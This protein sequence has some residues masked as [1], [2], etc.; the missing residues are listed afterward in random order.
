MSEKR[1]GEKPY[2]YVTLKTSATQDKLFRKL[3]GL[4]QVSTQNPKIKELLKK[5]GRYAVLFALYSELEVWVLLVT[6]AYEEGQNLI[7]PPVSGKIHIVGNRLLFPK[8]FYGAEKSI[9]EQQGLSTAIDTQVMNYLKVCGIRSEIEEVRPFS[10]P[11]EIAFM[12]RSMH[13][14]MKI[15]E[16]DY[17]TDGY[18]QRARDK[19][20]KKM[21]DWQDL[22]ERSRND[23]SVLDN[24]KL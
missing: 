2:R 20:L 7:Y 13:A 12:A 24:V 10:N 23:L 15:T 3:L 1:E 22:I 9:L 6:S 8:E 21:A 14:K 18:Y 4:G 19:F 17:P 5:R 16:S 11:Y